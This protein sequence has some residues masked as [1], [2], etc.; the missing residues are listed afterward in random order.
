MS[1][2]ILDGRWAVAIPT[3]SNDVTM[4]LSQRG[5]ST[6]TLDSLTVNQG[7]SRRKEHLQLP[8]KTRHGEPVH[9]NALMTCLIRLASRRLDGCASCGWKSQTQPVIDRADVALYPAIAVS[10][11]YSLRD[12]ML[13]IMFPLSG[14]V[15]AFALQSAGGM[16]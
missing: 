7:G 16:L 13:C 10:T 5:S 11:F 9:W 14:P 3:D 2:D 6:R 8:D 12:W 4:R 15:W 1:S